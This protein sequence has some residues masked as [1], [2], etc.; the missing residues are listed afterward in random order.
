MCKNISRK[1][2]VVSCE[3][4]RKLSRVTRCAASLAQFAAQ[5]WSCNLL[6]VLSCATCCA[7]SLVQLTLGALSCY[8]L[9]TCPHSTCSASLCCA[10]ISCASR[11]GIHRKNP[12][13]MLSGNNMWTTLVTFYV[14]LNTRSDLPRS[15]CSCQGNEKLNVFYFVDGTRSPYPPCSHAG[16]VYNQLTHLEG[17]CW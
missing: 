15:Q 1:S 5:A 14:S 12:F 4:L 9:C 8:L 6:C 3:I 13:V 17:K 2:Q 10:L 11:L 7:C 16:A